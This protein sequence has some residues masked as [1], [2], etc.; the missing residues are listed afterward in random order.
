MRRRMGRLGAYDES[1]RCWRAGP[2]GSDLRVTGGVL[3][4]SLA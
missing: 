4:V 3:G 2:V 1:Q